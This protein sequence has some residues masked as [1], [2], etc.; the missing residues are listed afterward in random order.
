ME[1]KVKEVVKTPKKEKGAFVSSI[2]LTSLSTIFFVIAVSMYTTI[3]DVMNVDPN[4]E[5]SALG[6]A[7]GLIFIIPIFIIAA[8]V[9]ICLAA[10]SFAPCILVIK[11]DK[12]VWGIISTALNGIYT[13]AIVVMSLILIV[14][15]Q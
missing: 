15:G 8:I 2:V 12:K 14:G 9:E 1:E 6:A 13:V 5:E 4:K 7:I 3:F 10:S 11:S